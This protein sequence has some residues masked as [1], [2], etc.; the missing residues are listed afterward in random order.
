MEHGQAILALVALA[1]VAA[2]I[3]RHELLAVTDAEHGAVGRKNRR[4]D[5]GAVAFV[6][7]IRAAG[8]DQPGAAAQFGRGRVAGRERRRTLPGRE[9]F[10]R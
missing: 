10:W 9:S 7:A 1:H 4:I 3:V 6:N 2:Q 5:A 8:N